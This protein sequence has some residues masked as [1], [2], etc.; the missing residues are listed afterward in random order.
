MPTGAPA[1]LARALLAQSLRVASP[2]QQPD[3]H[4]RDCCGGEQVDGVE[5]GEPLEQAVEELI[6]Q[7]SEDGANQTDN[8]SSP[9]TAEHHPANYVVHENSAA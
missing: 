6:S 4:H 5:V 1:Q 9:E 3:A 2:G 8:Q 7:A